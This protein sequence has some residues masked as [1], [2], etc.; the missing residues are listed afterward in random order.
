MGFGGSSIADDRAAVTGGSLRIEI[1]ADRSIRTGSG[2]AFEVAGHRGEHHPMGVSLEAARDRGGSI[3][4]TD[5]VHVL[6]EKLDHQQL[7]FIAI[8]GDHMQ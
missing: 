2:D 7:I 3:G 1:D 4:D 8:D 5:P 6:S